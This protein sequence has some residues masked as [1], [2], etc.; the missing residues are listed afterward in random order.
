MKTVTGRS[1]AAPLSRDEVA[2]RVGSPNHDTIGELQNLQGMIRQPPFPGQGNYVEFQAFLDQKLAAASAEV[3]SWED[4]IRRR[5]VLVR[6]GIADWKIHFELA[7]LNQKLEN[8]RAMYFHLGWVLKLYP[9]NRETYI[10][11]V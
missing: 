1:T 10:K 2:A 11:T 9:H 4:V 3:G 6:N 5:Q 7:V 8:W